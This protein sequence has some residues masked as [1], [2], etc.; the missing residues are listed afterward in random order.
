MMFGNRHIYDRRAN[1]LLGLAIWEGGG[2]A[3][4]SERGRGL[5]DNVCSPAGVG[6]RASQG[7]CRNHVGWISHGYS[8]R[9]G[10]LAADHD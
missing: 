7:G 10:A 2:R 3:E 5:N 8:A 9:L 1:V 6:D 4:N